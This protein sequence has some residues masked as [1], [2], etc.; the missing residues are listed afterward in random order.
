MAYSTLP[1]SEPG[2]QTPDR[3]FAGFTGEARQK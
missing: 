3:G 2:E 1:L